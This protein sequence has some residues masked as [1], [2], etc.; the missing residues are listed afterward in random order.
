MQHMICNMKVCL[1]TVLSLARLP[2]NSRPLV[3][4]KFWGSQKLY[5]DFR[6]E[7]STPTSLLFKGQLYV[8]SYMHVCA[9]D[10]GMCILCA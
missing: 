8:H 4:V 1:S 5:A 9:H 6:T 7:V 10:A 3:G 2:V